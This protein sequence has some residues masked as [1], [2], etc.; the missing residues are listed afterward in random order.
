MHI[1]RHIKYIRCTKKYVIKI[2]P[3]EVKAKKY[4]ILIKSTTI[5][6]IFQRKSQRT[7]EL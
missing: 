7:D 1:S 2:I 3:L 6:V 4:H 5:L